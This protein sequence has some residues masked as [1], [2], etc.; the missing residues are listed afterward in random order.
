VKLYK[1][2]DQNA[3]TMILEVPLPAVT[4]EQRV[5]FAI[6]CALKVCKEPSFVNWAN[7]WLDGSDSKRRTAR[8]WMWAAE[9]AAVTAWKAAVTAWKAADADGI[10]LAEIAMEA[11]K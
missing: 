2:T 10:N 5:K 9:P 1:L 11:C 6:L 4:D 7:G 8:E 3:Q